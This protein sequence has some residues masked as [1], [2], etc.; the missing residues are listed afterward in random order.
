M[1]GAP[2]GL[3]RTG[4]GCPSD[5]AAVR[6]GAAKR[7]VG[8]LAPVN[9]VVGHYGVGKTNFAL[10]LA[11]DAAAAG[12]EVV[13]A[14]MDVVNPYFR[15]SEYRGLLEDAGVRLVAPVFAGAGTSLDVPSLTGELFVA[16][17]EAYASAACADA[18]TDPDAA[19]P[20]KVVIIDAG[21]DDVGATALARFAP[22]IEAGPYEVLYVVNAFRNLTQDADAAL[23]VLREI[24]AKSHLAAT[25]VVGNSH[26]QRETTMG[27]IA[28]SV[29]FAQEVAARAGVALWCI[30]VPMSA[31]QRENGGVEACADIPESYPV[32]VLVSVPWA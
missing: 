26:L 7:I 23:S 15:S 30:T 25:A 19:A 8:R 9:V 28:E 3:P 21:G 27:H 18:A 16:V 4:G 5:G 22:A 32:Q 24:E 12:C 11:L 10:N 31:I 13:L 29:P 2:Q 6:A 20:R 1:A 14:D 17:E